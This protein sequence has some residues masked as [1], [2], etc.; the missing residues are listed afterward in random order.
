MI[1]K[2]FYYEFENRHRGSRSEIRGRLEIYNQTLELLEREL[3]PKNAIDYGC[4]RGEWLRLL[5]ER[6]WHVLGVDSN[7]DMLSPAQAD[8]LTVEVG[9]CLSHIASQPDNSQQPA[10][11]SQHP[12]AN[13]PNLE[14]QQSAAET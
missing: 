1:E 2:R 9:D 8:G 10:A 14:S 12:A 13:Y 7:D 5:S 11:C 4:G 3:L 6:S